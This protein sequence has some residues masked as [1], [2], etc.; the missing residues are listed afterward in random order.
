MGQQVAELK[1]ALQRKN[2][3]TDSDYHDMFKD[4]VALEEYR[5]TLKQLAIGTF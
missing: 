3:S 4:L 5:A 2:P 1:A